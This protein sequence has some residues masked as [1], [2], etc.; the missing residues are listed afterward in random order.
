MSDTE[1]VLVR[2][3][4]RDALVAEL[5]ALR[6]AFEREGVAHMVLFGSRARGD[7]RADSDVDLLVD[8]VPGRK[9]SMLN[10]I[11]LGHVVEDRIGLRGNVLIRSDLE[12]ALAASARRDAVEVF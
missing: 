4:G 2:D 8:V 9:F 3:I 6:P 11:G 7:N 12:K 5:R 1:T 10:L